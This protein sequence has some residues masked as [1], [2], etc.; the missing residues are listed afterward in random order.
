M[1]GRKR[2]DVEVEA[3]RRN[4]EARRRGRLTQTTLGEQAGVSRASVS[5]LERGRGGGLTLDAWQRM[6][7]AVGRPLVVRLQQPVDGETEDAG[8]LAIQELVLRLGRGAGYRGLVELATKPAEPWRSVDV[9]LVD[10]TRRRLAVVECWNSIGDVG[11]AARSSARKA[12]EAEAMAAARWG[13]GVPR[14]GS[15]WVVRATAR[16]RALVARY[17]EVFAARFPGS[18][19]AWVT[20][21]TT[22]APPPSEP[23]LVWATVDG[24]RLFAWRRHR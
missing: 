9:A 12:S 19:Q 1:A 21:L 20:A 10:D 6:A 24:K 5:R 15:V 4:A 11:A 18:S 13:E 3:A 2:T 17:P 23:G 14:V 8:H 7:L 22:Q 16:N